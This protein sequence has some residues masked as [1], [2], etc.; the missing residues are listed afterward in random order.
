MAHSAQ[1]WGLERGFQGFP[2]IV[3]S[4]RQLA[5]QIGVS[6]TML[7]RHLARGEFREEPGGGFDVAKVR[8]ALVRNTDMSLCTCK[9]CPRRAAESDRT[10]LPGRNPLDDDRTSALV[11]EIARNRKYS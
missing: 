3:R 8:A 10:A 4:I 7:N 9:D 5:Q 6:H 1:P 11:R 2:V